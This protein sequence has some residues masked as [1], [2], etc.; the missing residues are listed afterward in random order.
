[1]LTNKELLQLLVTVIDTELLEAVGVE[2]LEPVDV[3][4]A[5]QSALVRAARDVYC[6][7]YL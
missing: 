7:V 4:Y 5:N 6:F 3:E 1:M 2:Y